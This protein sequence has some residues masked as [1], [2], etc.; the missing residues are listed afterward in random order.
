MLNDDGAQETPHSAGRNIYSRGSRKDKTPFAMTMFTGTS[1]KRE[2]AL[3]VVNLL[4]N[5]IM[6]LRSIISM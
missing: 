4:T 2:T 6:D 3:D 1:C 5:S